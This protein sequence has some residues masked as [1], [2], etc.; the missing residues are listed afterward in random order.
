VSFQTPL[1]L[2][3]LLAIPAGVAAFLLWRRRA[4]RRA[5]PFPDLDVIA[6]AA[7]PPRL[8]RHA[9][10]VLAVLGL[11][12][13][14][15]ALARPEVARTV[16]RDRATIMLAIDIS[17]SMMADDVEPYRLRAAQD[18]AL[19]FADRVPRQFEVGLVSFSGGASVLLQPST[20]RFALKQ[21]IESLVPEG[22]TAIGDAVLASLEAIRAT[23]PGA[24][25]LQSARILL[26]SDG[27]N[28]NGASV[29]EAAQA[30]RALGVP[31]Y[32]VA[33][34]TPDG[35]VVSGGGITPVP[36]DPEALAALAEA[37]GGTAYESR[38]A[39]SVSKIY[40]RLGTFIG[41]RRVE[42]EVTAW[43]AGIAALLLLLAGAAAWRFGPRLP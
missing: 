29:P 33:L 24:T 8:R 42:D 30:A 21:A 1:A 40:E 15:F 18:A 17:R 11:A 7:P 3:T 19:R 39:D 16:P 13:I 34:G 4:G 2:L 14:G 36:P 37:T 38:A 23:Q 28:T 6:A 26:L 10:L 9:P 27:K 31:V 22:A 41:T 32:T 20:D 12:G 5:V 35:F 25:T 43:P